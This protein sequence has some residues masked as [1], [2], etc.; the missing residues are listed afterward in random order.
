MSVSAIDMQMEQLIKLLKTKYS[1]AF[2]QFKTP[3]WRG[4]SS[5]RSE[6]G[7]STTIAVEITPGTRKSEN[8]SNYYTE[9]LDHSPYMKGWPKRSESFICSTERDYAKDFGKL[10]AMFPANGT[11]I[12]VCPGF[13]IWTT[14]IR[15]PDL[16]V[17]FIKEDQCLLDFNRW[18]HQSLYFAD[19][20]MARMIKHAATPGFQKRIHDYNMNFD[21]KDFIP[22]LFKAFSPARTEF[23]LMNIAQV[24]ALAPTKHEVWFSSKCLAMSEKTW[25]TLYNKLYG[26][27]EHL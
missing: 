7:T 16:D 27:T 23:K 24:A 6:V 8:T 22:M 21:A 9:I 5:Y 3:L 25:L 14:K 4:W 18:M 19:D 20:D 10:F 26:S 11:K 15:L 1:Q 17:E 12:G 2:A 13:D